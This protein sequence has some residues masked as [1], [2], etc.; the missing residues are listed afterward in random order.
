VLHLTILANEARKVNTS[1]KERVMSRMLNS[2][3]ELENAFKQIITAAWSQKSDGHVEAPTGHFATIP[4]S[5]NEM[6]ELVDAVF[7]GELG[8]T[9]DPGYYFAKEDSAG[10]MW[11]WS[12]STAYEMNAMF[13][14][15]RR[16]YEEWAK[17]VHVL[18]CIVC[19]DEFDALDDAAEHGHSLPALNGFC[20][21]TYSR[22][23]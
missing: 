18:E 5:A 21:K 1:R 23:I 9:I 8:I 17:D 7:D 6:Q 11:L 19:G 20:I 13:E 3:R 14:R 10:N 2:D 12:F 4:I 15:Y 22:S 16:E